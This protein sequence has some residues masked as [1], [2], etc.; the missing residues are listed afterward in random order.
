ML[1]IV[2]HTLEQLI[3]KRFHE[4]MFQILQNKTQTSVGIIKM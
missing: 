2:I 4:H 3:N 1:T